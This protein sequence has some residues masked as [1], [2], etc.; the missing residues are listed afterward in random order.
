VRLAIPT[1]A[2]WLAFVVVLSLPPAVALSGVVVAL[3]L[4]WYQNAER[5]LAAQGDERIYEDGE[6][7]PDEPFE[8]EPPLFYV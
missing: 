2:I 7:E 8:R 5:R 3:L 4:G 6:D 1:L